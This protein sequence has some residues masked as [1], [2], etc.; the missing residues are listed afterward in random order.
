MVEEAVAVAAE[1]AAAVE[2]AEAMA[3][4]LVAVTVAATVAATAED[5][6]VAV[7]AVVLGEQ[8]IAARLH[9]RPDSRC[10]RTGV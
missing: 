6:L 5:Q 10:A 8:Q 2:T 3:A 9:F 4:E 1:M 7:A